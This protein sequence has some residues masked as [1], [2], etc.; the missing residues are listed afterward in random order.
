VNAYTP[1]RCGARWLDGD[2]PKEILAI[3]DHGPNE[4]ERFD[5]I[6]AEMLEDGRDQWLTYLSLT[7]GGSGYH[8]EL[9]AHEVAAYR[10]RMK[11]RYTTWSGLPEVVKA[12]VRRDIAA[13][14][15]EIEKWSHA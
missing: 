7:D 13:S 4:L 11:H 6:Y 8:G 15:A 9:K 10:Y 2:C 14:T 5:V 12:A 3:V 1:R